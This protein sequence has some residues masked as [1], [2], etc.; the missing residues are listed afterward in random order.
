[1]NALARAVGLLLVVAFSVLGMFGFQATSEADQTTVSTTIDG[2]IAALGP[3]VLV[4]VALPLLAC[5]AGGSPARVGRALRALLVE[6]APEE[7][8]AVATTL[9]RLARAT[10]AAGLFAA[11]LA[12]TA[13]FLMVGRMR[14]GEASPA[15]VADVLTWVMLAPALA[16]GIAR[17]ACAPAADALWARAG[18]DERTFH[19]G[20]DLSQVF[21][22][23]PA[24]LAWA[25]VFLPADK[26]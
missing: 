4:V 6:P 2:L 26:L 20:D 3:K 8:E 9:A 16:L 17:L 7:R 22:I 24:L 5:L 21:L 1:M 18:S 19:P 12:V 23:V 15:L 13:L 14:M 25:L 11:L 10:H